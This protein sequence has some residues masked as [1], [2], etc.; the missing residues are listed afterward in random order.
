MFNIQNLTVVLCFVCW[1]FDWKTSGLRLVSAL[2]C[3]TPLG[4]VYILKPGCSSWAL[5]HIGTE[6]KVLFTK[7]LRIQKSHLQIAAFT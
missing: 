3:V 2:P 1:T 5:P 4:G 6:G 7:C